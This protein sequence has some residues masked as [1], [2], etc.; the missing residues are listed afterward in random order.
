MSIKLH[1][2]HRLTLGAD[3][4][5]FIVQARAVLDPV[6]DRLDARLLAHTAAI[7]IDKAIADGTATPEHPVS[8]AYMA[9][10]DDQAKLS[11]EDRLQ[12]PNRF[13]LT[14]GR[15]PRTGRLGVLTYVE[16]P[17]LLS[18]FRSLPHV[19]QYA[20]W[21]NTDRPKG[22]TAKQWETR[23]RFWDRLVGWDPPA[24]RMFSWV[25]RT[26]YHP[27][28]ILIAGFT[29]DE[30]HPLVIEEV[31]DDDRR[32][33]YLARRAVMN[34][35][36]RGTTDPNTVMRTMWVLADDRRYP[37]VVD[38]A[39]PLL[40]HITPDALRGTVTPKIEDVEAKRSALAAAAETAATRLVKTDGN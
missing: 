30:V 29:K 23:A 35:G 19:E 1:H 34:A 8:A 22:V 18:T 27:G 20:Y 39:R 11:K 9:N 7:L 37:E 16:Q 40:V 24:E 17:E 33:R 36:Y 4:F 14:I 25:L 21:D 28:M 32:S 13:E 31:P 10:E 38:L 26:E 2:G 12:D 3:P 15:D 6:R 5:D